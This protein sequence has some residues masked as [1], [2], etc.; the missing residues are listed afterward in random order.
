LASFPAA[1]RARRP[2]P[3]HGIATIDLELMAEILEE[4]YRGT[5]GADDYA[6]DGV[7]TYM[8]CRQIML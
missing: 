7:T 2:E 3:Q 1:R 6:E 8:V 5:A 4:F